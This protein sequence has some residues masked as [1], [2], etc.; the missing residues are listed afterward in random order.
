MGN[1]TASQRIHEILTNLNR[2][3]ELMHT[4]SLI[5]EPVE[6]GKFKISSQSAAGGEAVSR[7]ERLAH[8]FKFWHD[9]FERQNICQRLCR[10]F[11]GR[12]DNFISDS[13]KVVPYLP[14]N[15][16]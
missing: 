6:T 7:T 12:T 15:V 2:R 1:Q 16:F 5:A 14:R 9:I 13:H 4:L 8:D 11:E 3:S 10:S